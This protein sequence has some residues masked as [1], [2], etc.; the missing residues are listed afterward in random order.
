MH[1]IK[2]FMILICLIT[3]DIYLDHLDRLVSARLLPYKVTLFPFIVNKYLW[4]DALRLQI[5]FL[6]K[7]LLPN[8]IFFCFVCFF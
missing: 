8:F 5:L 2:G 3:G 4:G 7:L 6:L 1:H